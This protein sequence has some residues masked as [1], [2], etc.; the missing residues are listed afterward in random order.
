VLWYSYTAAGAAIAYQR[1]TAVCYDTKP[2]GMHRLT[3]VLWELASCKDSE[4]PLA[5]WVGLRM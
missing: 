5:C 3:A 1:C 2:A 4:P